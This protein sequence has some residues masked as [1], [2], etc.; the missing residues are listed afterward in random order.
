MTAILLATS[1]LWGRAQAPAHAQAET[2]PRPVPDYDGRGEPPTTAGDVVI[3]F[4]RVLLSPL[5]IASEYVLRRPLGLL[6]VEIER[7]DA[8]FLVHAFTLSKKSNFGIVPTAYFEFGFH[9][10]AGVYVFADHVLAEPH[11][12]RLHAATGGVHYWKVTFEDRLELDPRGARVSLR[13]HASNRRDYLFSGIG[14]DAANDLVSRYRSRRLDGSLRLEL[15]SWAPLGLV[16]ELG[17]RDRDF[18]R[19]ACCDDPGVHELVDQGTLAALPPGF[20]EGFTAWFQ[21]LEL[22]FD[23]RGHVGDHG[24][25]LEVYGEQAFDLDVLARRWIAYG[26]TGALYFPTVGPRRTMGLAVG[27]YFVDPLGDAEVPFSEQAL[28]G[29]DGLLRGFREGRLHG[30]S[31]LVASL[32]Y[33][34]P[35]WVWLQAVLQVAAGNVYGPHLAGLAPESLRGSAAIGFR[36]AES[37]PDHGFELLFAL[38]TETVEQGMGIDTVRV[39]LGA[40]EGF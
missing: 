26:A 29:G 37:S 8:H 16:A 20:A 7:G 22:A 14:P 6:I 34:W 35:L 32:E 11:G 30:R 24:H 38:G 10:N 15:E 31:A 9:A 23:S 2:E 21:R 12:F 4:P 39:L 1:L 25:R 36:T 17:V 40:T 3:W 33:Q 13:V 28:L 27:A 18:G 5:Y 19:G